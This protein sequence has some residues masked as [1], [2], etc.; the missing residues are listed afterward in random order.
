MTPGTKIGDF[1]IRTRLGEGGPTPLAHET[2]ASSGEVSP[3]PCQWRM[4]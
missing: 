3:K 1:E 2:R 4:R